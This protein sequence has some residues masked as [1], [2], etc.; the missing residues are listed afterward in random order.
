MAP[1]GR[2]SYAE[3]CSQ[4]PRKENIYFEKSADLII[5]I[6][7]MTN[8]YIC[9]AQWAHRNIQFVVQHRRMECTNI[10]GSD[11][12]FPVSNFHLALHD[13]YKVVHHRIGVQPTQRY[14]VRHL[15]PIASRW[16]QFQLVSDW[17]T[18]EIIVFDC[19]SEFEFWLTSNWC[20]TISCPPY[21][22]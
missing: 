7:A 9:V 10:R 18:K 4:E 17:S 2:A 15:C 3:H 16:N 5:L 13:R 19:L 8:T 11:E 22:T 6:S 20:L 21:A 14:L 1:S 12:L